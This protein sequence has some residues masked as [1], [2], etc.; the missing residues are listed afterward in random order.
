MAE[1]FAM[2]GYAGYVWTAYGVFFL[3]LL[4][5]AIAPLLQRRRTMAAL[6]SRL[7]REAARAQ[8]ENR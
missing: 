8:R 3:T 6:R 4:A 2:H 7:K 1:F 5:D